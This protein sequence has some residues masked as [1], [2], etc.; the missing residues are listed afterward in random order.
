MLVIG[1]TGGIGSG[2][3]TVANLFADLGVPIIDADVIAREVTQIGQPALE[4]IAQHFGEN[5]LAGDGS[6]NR[7]KLREL[8]F[9]Q[10]QEK[11]WL[12]NLLHPLIRQHIETQIAALKA[13]YCIAVIPLLFEGKGY[14]FIDRIL[15]VDTPSH[16]Q[17]ERTVKRDNTSISAVQSIINSQ[18]K[19]DIRLAKADDVIKNEGGLAELR[20]KV[21]ILNSHYLALTKQ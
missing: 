3:T 16:L 20:E 4:S 13:P 9:K 7:S 21:R 11:K 17:I 12:E 5:I 18:I 2:K 19:Q 10:P 8:I 15:V 6:L 14:T 1:L